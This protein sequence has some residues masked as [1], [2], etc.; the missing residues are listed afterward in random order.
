MQLFPELPVLQ[1]ELAEL[2][3]RRRTYVVRVVAICA[4]AYVI[5]KLVLSYSAGEAEVQ[6]VMGAQRFEAALGAGGPIFEGLVTSLFWCIKLMMPALCCA[7]VTT[8]KERNTMGIL[9]TTKL[10]PGAIVLEKLLS[11]VIP[12]LTILLLVFPVLGYLYSLGGVDLSKLSGTFWLLLLECFLMASI[13]MMYSCWFPTTAMA[14]IWSYVTVAV[15]VLMGLVTRDSDQLFLLPSELWDAG[16]RASSFGELLDE[17]M[18]TMIVIASLLVLSR[19][20]LVGRAFVS[21]RSITLK[22]FRLLDSFFR[23]LNARTTGGIELIRDR[24]DLPVHR[25]LTWREE[26]RKALGKVRYLFRILVVLELP[27]FFLCTLSAIASNERAFQALFYVEYVLW[28]LGALIVTVKSC[29]LMSSEHARETMSALL[30]TPLTASEILFQKI[31]G[32]RRLLCVVAIPMATV[33][34]THYLLFGNYV[35]MHAIGYLL[36]SITSI[37]L[38][39]LS[40]AILGTIVG[41]RVRSQTKSVLISITLLATWCALPLVASTFAESAVGRAAYITFSPYSLLEASERFLTGM[42]MFGRHWNYVDPIGQVWW[43]PVLMIY[44]IGVVACLGFLHLRGDQLLGRPETFG[45]RSSA[46]RV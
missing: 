28:G 42:L 35:S 40:V 37:V 10:T 18:G 41:T 38:M 4:M 30:A 21:E 3:S 43:I 13:A 33:S 6:T 7:V 24:N 36:V 45:G 25:P 8:E 22:L 32:M 29:T 11:R 20:F 1:R 5:W 16:L 26:S 46:E 15:L 14:F 39:L 19:F 9:L 31:L 23:W 17:T 34:V 12:M 44:L 2:A 27:T